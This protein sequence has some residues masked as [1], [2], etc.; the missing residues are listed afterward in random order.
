MKGKIPFWGRWVT[1]ILYRFVVGAFGVEK[2]H[3]YPTN[4]CPAL[5]AVCV[6]MTIGLPVVLLGWLVRLT[7]GRGRAQR[8]GEAC[9]SALNALSPSVKHALRIA[10]VVIYF[11]GVWA[12]TSWSAFDKMGWFAV[13]LFPAVMV[14]TIAFV[15]GAYKLSEYWA[16]REKKSRVV[17]PSPVITKMGRDN[18]VSVKIIAAPFI[19]AGSLIYSLGYLCYSFYKR[20]CPY[21]ELP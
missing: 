9:S 2:P 21:E 16:G 6:G 20:F 12:L 15:F 3:P 1:S 18:R 10:L 14:G 7:L 5:W 13:I 4:F 11:L 19:F 8:L 17:K